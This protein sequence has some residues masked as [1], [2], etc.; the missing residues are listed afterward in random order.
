MRFLLMTIICIIVVSVWFVLCAVGAEPPMWTFDDKDAEKEL[1]SWI[2]LTQLVPLEIKEVKDKKGEK[3]SVLKTKSL[4]GDPYMFPGGGWNVA[5][6]EPIDGT[7]YNILYMGVRVNLPNTWQVYYYSKQEPAWNENQR[8]NYDVNSVDDFEDIEVEIT[9][10]D[11]HKRDGIRFRIDPGTAQG[12]EAEID[13]IS[14]TGSPNPVKA[15]KP[16]GN[17][18]VTWGSLK[19]ND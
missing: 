11:W 19:H 10:G 7:K 18:A 15:V 3:R 17:I 2:D 8:Q 5:N 14:F 1:K 12:V 9:L 13:Y 4:G 16:A 6:Y